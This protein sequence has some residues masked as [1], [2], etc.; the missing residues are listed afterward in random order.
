MNPN[1]L[2]RTARDTWKEVLEVDIEDSADF[3]EIGGH[4]F[5]AMEIIARLDAEYGTRIPLRLLYDNPCFCD[6][7]R[8]LIDHFNE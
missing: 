5:M 4:S 2:E 1:T 3:F 8:A 6:F 7:T